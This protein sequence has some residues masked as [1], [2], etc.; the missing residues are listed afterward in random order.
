MSPFYCLYSFHWYNVVTGWWIQ[1]QPSYLVEHRHHSPTSHAT[2]TVYVTI[3][4][5]QNTSQYLLQSW[6][7]AAKYTEVFLKV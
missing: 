4:S 2:S 3:L 1:G 6:V 5:G 7:S